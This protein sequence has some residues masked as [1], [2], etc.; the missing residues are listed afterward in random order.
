M[1]IN[2][3]IIILKPC[4]CACILAMLAFL[5]PEGWVGHH[6]VGGWGGS[7]WGVIDSVHGGW[8]CC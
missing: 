6:L 4:A 8:N 3:W 1:S 5:F 7:A 2:D